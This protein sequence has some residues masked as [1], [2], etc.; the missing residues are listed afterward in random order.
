MGRSL[1]TKYAEAA[2]SKDAPSPAPYPIQ[3]Y[4]T[5]E[6]RTNAIKSNTL[7]GMQAWAGQSAKLAL[8]LS[9]SEI[10]SKIWK[11]TKQILE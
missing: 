5:Q 6:M 7:D 2:N 1:R 8:N 3:R 4:L 10:V 11:D 9:A